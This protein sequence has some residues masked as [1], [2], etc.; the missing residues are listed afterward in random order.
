MLDIGVR[1]ANIEPHFMTAVCTVKNIAKHIIHE[2]HSVGIAL[3]K[4]DKDNVK[5][6]H[7]FVENKRE[8]LV[9]G[10]CNKSAIEDAKKKK[11]D[12]QSEFIDHAV[13]TKSNV[14]KRNL[15]ACRSRI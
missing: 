14:R 12:S 10:H 15:N 1:M 2:F 8:K 11:G 13:S 5:H 7:G 3:V 9:I 4:I 6:I